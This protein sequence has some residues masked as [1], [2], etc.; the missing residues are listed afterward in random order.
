MNPAKD[1]RVATGIAGTF[2]DLAPLITIWHDGSP[3]EAGTAVTAATITVVAATTNTITLGING[4]VDARIGTAGV[5]DCENA[6]YNTAGEVY[7]HINSVA[8]WNCRIEGMLRAGVLAEGGRAIMVAAAEQTCFKTPVTILRDSDVAS[9]AAG[10]EHGVV[11]SQ[12]QAPTFGAAR[13]GKIRAIENEHGFRNV[14][15]Y[16]SVTLTYAADSAVLYVYQINGT[17]ETLLYQETAAATTVAG[18]HTPNKPIV[19][20]P[21][22]HLLILAVNVSAVTACTMANHGKSVKEVNVQV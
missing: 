8:G 2:T 12:R 1:V 7:D 16:M 9:K 19:A 20:D 21:G 4:A 22:Y 14:L 15:D 17:T 13:K 3:T 10:F 11:I 6:A 18:V 5:I